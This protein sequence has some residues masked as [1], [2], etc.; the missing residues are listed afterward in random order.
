MIKNIVL[1]PIVVSLLFLAGAGCSSREKKPVTLADSTIIYP[2]KKTDGLTATIALCRKIDKKTGK[3]I[4]EGTAFTIMEK[5]RAHAIADIPNL[6]L[7]EG[8]G[9]MFHFN[10]IGPNG[11][12]FFKKQIDIFPN[13][14]SSSISSTISIKPGT[15]QAGDYKI[16]LYFFR[17]LIAEKKFTLFPE[18]NAESFFADGTQQNIG[19][20]KKAKNETGNKLDEDP[21]FEMGQKEKVKAFF[22]LGKH[23]DYGARELLFRFE[24]SGEDTTAFYRKRIALSPEDS[25]TIIKS[26]ISIAPKKRKEGNY[27][28]KLFLFNEFIAEKK[29]VLIPEPKT[30]PIKAQI[31][32]YRKLDKKTVKRIG[33]G[34][35]FK[36]GKKRK[37]RASVTLHNCSVNNKR[38]LEFLI[39]WV[40]PD[41]KVFYRKKVKLKPD[42]HALTI[43][44]SISIS[45]EKRQPG[46]YILSVSLFNKQL[47]KKSFKLF[48]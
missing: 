17:E 44:S 46:N 47:A 15:R 45:P 23:I 42:N 3:R 24:W 40:G 31:G 25:S 21:V 48:E 35:K 9:L 10:W 26:S 1:L 2:S 7:K 33:E 22:H 5:T 37:V 41:T 36:I 12:S 20:F 4:G 16:Q 19:L 6:S 30:P 43:K 39:E 34:T 18:F 32:F 38:D 14:S 8:K 28:V 11:K 27:T 13:D 29:F